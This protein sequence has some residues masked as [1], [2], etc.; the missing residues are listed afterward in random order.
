MLYMKCLG[1]FLGHDKCSKLWGLTLLFIYDI[2]TVTK[3]TIVSSLEYNLFAIFVWACLWRA[4]CID[5]RPFCLFCF[6]SIFF[7][8]RGCMIC[9]AVHM[10]VRWQL[11]RV[12][13]FHLLYMFICDVG[14]ELS[15]YACKASALSAVKSCQP[16]LLLPLV[17]HSFRSILLRQG[18]L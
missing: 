4:W 1:I 2:L 13:P 11:C 12:N 3:S 15:S 17:H 18:L 7:N 16:L 14:L 6:V 5:Y 9:V 10:D 8:C